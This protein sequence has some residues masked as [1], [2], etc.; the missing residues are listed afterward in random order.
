MSAALQRPLVGGVKSQ[1][2]I[3]SVTQTQEGKLWFGLVCSFS[4]PLRKVECW[5]V[6][7]E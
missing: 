7:P 2:S 1:L 3:S 6:F 5:K 4:A